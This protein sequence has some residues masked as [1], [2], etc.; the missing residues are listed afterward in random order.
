[1]GVRHPSLL[2][3]CVISRGQPYE[4]ILPE[5]PSHCPMFAHLCL[6]GDLSYFSCQIMPLRRQQKNCKIFPN[7]LDIT[8]KENFQQVLPRKG[9]LKA[10][11]H[12]K[13]PQSLS[14]SLSSFWRQYLP[15]L[16]QELLPFLLFM[17]TCSFHK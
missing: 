12:L 10:L 8:N 7:G 15:N 1:M 4:A 3:S 17:F 2:K 5:P 11:R 9:T 14:Y 16:T 6:F 13:K